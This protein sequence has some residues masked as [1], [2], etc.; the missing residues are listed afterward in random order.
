MRSPLALV[1]LLVARV[2]VA[3][4]EPIPWEEADKH[5][6]EDVLRRALEAMQS[7]STTCCVA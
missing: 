2:V 1:V 3:A 4:D 7:C 6:G 5:V